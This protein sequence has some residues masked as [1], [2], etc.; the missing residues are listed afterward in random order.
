MTVI[1]PDIEPLIVDFYDQKIAESTEYVLQDVRV[2]TKK[3]PPG[4][5]MVNQIIVT[6]GY[7]QT[8]NKVMREATVTVDVFADGYGD[9]S[10]IASLA[11]GFSPDLADDPIKF[12]VVSLGPIRVQEESKQERRSFTVDLIVKGF[13]YEDPANP[14]PEPGS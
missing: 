10:S 1:F 2:G 14:L 9:A 6:A 13:D 8:I 7:G 3:L 12:A 4:T 5:G 11:A